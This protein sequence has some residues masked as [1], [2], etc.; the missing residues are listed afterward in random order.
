[1][2]SEKTLKRIVIFL[3]VLLIAGFAVIVGTI[4]FRAT[5]LAT[6]DEVAQIDFQ[7]APSSPVLF[8]TPEG[9]ELIGISR[10]N[11]VFVVHIRTKEGAEQK[12]VFNSQTGELLGYLVD[13]QP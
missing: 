6:K 3:G 1:M 10:E 8:V 2:P 7:V 11:A 12:L 13:D 9:A 4:I 5:K